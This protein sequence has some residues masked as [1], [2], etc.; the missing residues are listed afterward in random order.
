[1]KKAVALG[2]DQDKNRAPHVVAKGK[3]ASAENIIKIAQLH[4]LPIKEDADLVELLS[5]VELD[6]EVPEK[7]YVAVAEVFSFL[8][9]I[10]KK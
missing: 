3:G 2:Y 10:T 6:R 5:K 7:L 8:Y 9:K 4:N 1:M